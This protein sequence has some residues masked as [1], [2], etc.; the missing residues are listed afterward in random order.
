[1]ATM[2]WTRLGPPNLHMTSMPCWRGAY[3]QQ[4]FW[5][6]LLCE[7]SGRGAPATHTGPSDIIF[8]HHPMEH[9]LRQTSELLAIKWGHRLAPPLL[10]SPP[11]LAITHGAVLVPQ[12]CT[13]PR[14]G[15]APAL[16]YH[17]LCVYITKMHHTKSV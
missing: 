14:L 8:L 3:Q 4:C 13:L 17:T 6:H 7:D 1:M 12:A 11:L 15:R 10:F 5:L 9:R 2:I 16:G